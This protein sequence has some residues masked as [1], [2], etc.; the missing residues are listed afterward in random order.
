MKTIQYGFLFVV[1]FIFFIHFIDL[2]AKPI[3][4][5]GPKI[6]ITNMKRTDGFGSNMLRIMAA[7]LY[8]ELNNYEFFYQPFETMEHNYSGNAND[9]AFLSKKESIINCINN[10][11][12]LDKAIAAGYRINAD[13]HLAFLNAKRYEFAE[14]SF[15]KKMR[16]LFRV[17]KN[18]SDYFDDHY[19]NIAVHIRRPNAHDCCVYG[20]DVPSEIYST[21]IRKLREIYSDKKPL[22]FHIFSQGNENDFKEFIAPDTIFHINEDSNDTY[23]AMAFADVLIAGR[24]S[25]GYTA[26]YFNEGIV[27]YVSY[28]HATLPHWIAIEQLLN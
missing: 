7:G 18:K 4:R 8:A 28:F 9:P 1:N 25:F 19:Y 22:L 11:P 6:V 5:M 2:W 12:T 3:E 14:S 20:T 26:G 24:S 10:F 16:S 13:D 27:Y 17:G 21:A 23:I 15:L